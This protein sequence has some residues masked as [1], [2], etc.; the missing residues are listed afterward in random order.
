M[1][2]VR[3]SP[4]IYQRQVCWTFLD[5]SPSLH[6][7]DVPPNPFV[8][9][10]Y[11]SS[12]CEYYVMSDAEYQHTHNTWALPGIFVTSVKQLTK[13]ERAAVHLCVEGCKTPVNLKSNFQYP[14]KTLVRNT[15]APFCRS[16]FLARRPIVSHYKFWPSRIRPAHRY[17]HR[18]RTNEDAI[19]SITTYWGVYENNR[20]LLCPLGDLVIIL[21]TAT[22]HEYLQ[23]SN[24]AVQ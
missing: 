10:R 14:T 23:S 20:T 8:M 11:D 13:L 24:Q 7:F 19:W 16:L 18:F 3:Q 9:L 22:L 1:K 21:V 4:S 5:A 6:I 2:T 15:K 12:W 17:E